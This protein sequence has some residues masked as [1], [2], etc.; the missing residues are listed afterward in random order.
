MHSPTCSNLAKLAIL[1]SNENSIPMPNHFVGSEFTF[2]AVDNFDHSDKNSLSGMQSTHDTA[3]ILCQTTP[4][5][6]PNK[7]CKDNVNLKSV[8]SVTELPC[9][10]VLN[11]TSNKKISLPGTFSVDAELFKNSSKVNERGNVEFIISCIKSK[12]LTSE[13]NITMPSW[14][15]IR[16]L[17]SKSNVPI[18]QVGFLPMIP[19]PV[20]EHSTVYAAM[21]NFLKVLPQ[22]DQRS[23]PVFCDEGVYRLVVEI[24]LKCPEKFKPLVPCLGGFHMAK[25]LQYCIGKYIK[26]T[27]LDDVL[28]ET[29]IFGKK[30][31]EQILHGTHYVRSLRGFIIIGEAIERL[32]WKAFFEQY[33]K[34][35]N[36]DFSEIQKLML[37]INNK[38][39]ENCV[40][41]VDNCI[42]NIKSMKDD[43]DQFASSCSRNSEVC[44]YWEGFLNLCSLMK[45][46]IA[47][48]R[49]RDWQGHLQT[50][51]EL[52][53]VFL[54]CDSIY[55]I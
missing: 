21:N 45:S 25:C 11:F 38:S 55:I 12:V 20:T 48:D 34:D 14:A 8:K 9:Q 23:M 35:K 40:S 3:M 4:D 6:I 26:G 17:I 19:H 1:K 16:S 2:A 5:R 54:E 30:T 31:I 28:L 41:I 15:S 18:M 37:E 36:Y 7:P 49:A 24:Y 27:G 52:L 22:L 29:N 51:Q 32:K 53:P 33:G 46:L 50:V 39:N 43:F 13:N 47:C 42:K 10:R 44:K